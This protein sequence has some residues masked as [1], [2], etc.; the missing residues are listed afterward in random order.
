[1]FTLSC[2]NEFLGCVPTG[3]SRALPSVNKIALELTGGA[4]RIWPTRKEGL[5]ASESSL[6]YA[7]LHKMGVENWIPS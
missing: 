4:K 2:Y 3:S 7:L 1:M 5:A 6:K